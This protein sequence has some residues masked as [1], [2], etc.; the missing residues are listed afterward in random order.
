MQARTID[1]QF[2]DS[3]QESGLQPSYKERSKI[4]NISTSATPYEEEEREVNN[5][6]TTPSNAPITNRNTT[7]KSLRS[8]KIVGETD[9]K[10]A[11]SKARGVNLFV[12]SFGLTT[13]LFFQIPF[14]LLSIV[15]LGLTSLVAYINDLIGTD[16]DP[17][18][19]AGQLDQAKSDGRDWMINQALDFMFGIDL[20]WL[21]VNNLFFISVSVV[22][23]FGIV[24]LL[25]IFLIYKVAGLNPIFGNKGGGVKSGMV[26]LA[27]IGYIIPILNLFPW[28]YLWT[29]AVQ[30]YP[31]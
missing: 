18:T 29:M 7:S 15:F 24:S 8:V 31:K 16:Y 2:N 4:R 11:K 10:L 9:S 17:K 27:T 28:F 23:L 6:Q 21:D 1:Q 3:Y 20:S 26:L 25:G 19:I 22:A 30:K 14:A 5:V 12:R 13:W